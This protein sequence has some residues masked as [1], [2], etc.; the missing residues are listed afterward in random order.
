MIIMIIYVNLIIYAEN[1][2]I[3]LL[4]YVYT[5]KLYK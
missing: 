4:K 3:C 2:K 1:S 5:I